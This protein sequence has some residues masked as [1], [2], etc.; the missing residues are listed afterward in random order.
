M[1]ILKDTQ[2]HSTRLVYIQKSLQNSLLSF[3]VSNQGKHNTVTVIHSS[4]EKSLNEQ[5]SISQ[6]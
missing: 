6:S 4:T 2:V 1:H 3:E 5:P